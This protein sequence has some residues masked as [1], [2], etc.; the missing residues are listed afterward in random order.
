MTDVAAPSIAGYDDGNLGFG[1]VGREKRVGDAERFG[2][3]LGNESDRVRPGFDERL[4]VIEL[5][6]IDHV[7]ETAVQIL[8]SRARKN[9]SI[10]GRVAWRDRANP[11]TARP[12][13]QGRGSAVPGSRRTGLPGAVGNRDAF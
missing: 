9:A 6:L 8:G 12:M 11:R 10:G 1:V 13:H 5:V 2:S 4:H 3:V 7:K